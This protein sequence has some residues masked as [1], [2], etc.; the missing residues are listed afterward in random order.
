MA[1]VRYRLYNGSGR[2]KLRH[3]SFNGRGSFVLGVALTVT[4][5]TSV[6]VDV[7]CF[8]G[9][10]GS[11]TVAASGGTSPYIYSLDS[12][13][14]TYNSTGVFSGLA[15][16]GGV[17]EG[18]DQYG[19]ILICNKT[20]YAR[21]A[22]GRIG[23]VDV[24]LKSPV[25]LDWVLPDNIVH[26]ATADEISSG[27]ATIP[28]PFEPYITTM[29]NNCDFFKTYT[30]SDNR[31]PFNPNSDTT[32]INMVYAAWNDCGETVDKHFTITIYKFTLSE[33]TSA[34]QDVTCF[35]GD[36]GSITVQ[37]SGGIAPYL[38]SIDGT[39]WQSSP[40]FS[41][42]AITGPVTEGTD[43]YGGILICTKT[44]YVKDVNNYVAS[45]DVQLK[46]PVEL[47]W[48]AP[49]SSITVHCDEGQNYATVVPGVD[50]VEPVLSTTANGASEYI[51][52]SPTGVTQWPVGTNT[53]Q[54]YTGDLCYQEAY[55]IFTITVLPNE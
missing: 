50:F 53:I 33:D 14:S 16:S 29:A 18:T 36:D 49:Q 52:I 2:Y 1:L 37:A 4:E 30:P 19:G 7:T 44:I 6:H 12:S 13:F 42:L 23:H 25:E 11:V 26:Y 9:S 31:Y 21:D 46:S 34:H 5:D 48:I 8:D 20:I 38:Y 15:I 24:Q 22:N 51:D 17:E 39:N 35:D 47:E 43:Q 28:L 32:V 45:L 55:F 54:Y 27:Y 41:N 40:T 3:P 10:D